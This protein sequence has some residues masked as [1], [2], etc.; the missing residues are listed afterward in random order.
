[1]KGNDEGWRGSGEG[2]GEGSGDEGWRRGRLTK[3]HDA[4]QHDPRKGCFHY[5]CEVTLNTSWELSS[6]R[7]QQGEED[8]Q[9]ILFLCAVRKE[10]LKHRV[11]GGASGRSY[12]QCS[13]RSL[14]GGASA[15]AGSVMGGA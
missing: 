13:G 11:W 3:P 9:I 7:T 14:R 4:Q 8:T 2:S 15:S 1:M 6:L 12:M 10:M 5:L